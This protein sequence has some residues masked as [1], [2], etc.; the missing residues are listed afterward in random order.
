MKCSMCKNEMP[1]G[2]GK[3]FVKNDGKILYFCSSKCQRN[4]FMGRAKKG[5]RWAIKK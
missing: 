1:K 5:L 2:K 3:M 4:W